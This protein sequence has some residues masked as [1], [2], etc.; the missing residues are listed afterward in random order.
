[1]AEVAMEVAVKVGAATGLV[2]QSD[3]WEGGQMVA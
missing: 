2:A 1:M 3:R